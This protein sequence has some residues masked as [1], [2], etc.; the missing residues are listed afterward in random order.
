MTV[1]LIGQDKKNGAT[2]KLEV[3]LAESQAAGISA[4]YAINGNVVWQSAK[5]YAD[6][7]AKAPI[8]KET[9]IR[10]ASISKSMTALAVM[11]LWEQGKLDLDAPIQT[12]IPDYPTH[13][14]TQITTRHLLSHTSGI[15]G[16][17]NTK[18]QNTIKEY[19]SLTDAL[20]LFKTRELLFEPG[21]KYSY[22]TYG[23]TVL[24]VIVE[25]VSGMD[26]EKYMQQHIWDRAAM[27]E[28]GVVKFG[29]APENTSK[30]YHR[31]GGKG[32]ARD[33]I[34]NNLSNRIP[35][36][37]FYTTVTD[38]LKFGNAVIN[39][40]FVKKETL[41]YMREHHSLEKERNAYGF[42]WYLY[43]AKPNEGEL[44]GH[45]GAQMGASSQ[46]WIIPERKI[47]VIVLVNT[48]RVEV[49]EFA[50]DLL[51]MALTE[52]K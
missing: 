37:G 35:G 50:Y 18:E 27:T 29:A 46:L 28:T 17:K 7:K 3:F 26:F 21:T 42:G 5:G 52:I 44:I 24:G 22:T 39:N 1:S 51:K 4:G 6:I 8:G 15:S 30:I 49:G 9:K 40:V 47:V 25:R 38:M 12:Y 20:D 11:Q 10:M 31:K 33:G 16:Y 23:Y 14:S 41:D 32:K 34:D 36:G 43:G 13:P 45:S 48:S 19:K 2:E